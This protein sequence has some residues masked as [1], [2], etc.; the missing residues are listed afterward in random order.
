[1][2][3]KKSSGMKCRKE[4]KKK[5]R[6]RVMST[7]NC[8]FSHASLSN[9]PWLVCDSQ[10]YSLRKLLVS[11]AALCICSGEDRTAAAINY[12]ARMPQSLLGSQPVCHQHFSPQSA[13][14]T[15]IFF[16]FL[17][18]NS[19]QKYWNQH[20]EDSIFTSGGNQVYVLIVKIHTETDLRFS[21]CGRGHSS[22]K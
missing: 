4:R 15:C 16:F 2:D 13:F 1:M 20:L 5:K 11:D 17:G 9:S 7:F 3:R 8:F 22:G 21:Q 19:S 14:L 12:S 6:M 18:T 10:V